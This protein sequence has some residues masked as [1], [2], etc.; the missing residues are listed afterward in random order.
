M[1]KSRYVMQS[2][3]RPFRDGNRWIPNRKILED[4]FCH[5]GIPWDAF[6]SKEAI[7]IHRPGGAVRKVPA[8]TTPVEIANSISPRLAVLA[9]P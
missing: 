7:A 5:P 2:V 1:W 3:T 8:C 4:P 9:A 6:L